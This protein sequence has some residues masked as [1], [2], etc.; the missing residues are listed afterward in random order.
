HKKFVLGQSKRLS[1]NFPLL[2]FLGF[3]PNLKILQRIFEVGVYYLVVKD[4]VVI[5][6]C[7]VFSGN[8]LKIA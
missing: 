8:S 2:L 4:Q 6:R 7:A 3:V 1:F 5:L